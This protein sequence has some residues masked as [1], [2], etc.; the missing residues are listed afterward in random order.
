MHNKKLIRII[1]FAIV[2]A[3]GVSSFAAIFLDFG[4]GAFAYESIRGRTVSFYYLDCSGL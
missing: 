3:A 2:L 4:E 1:V